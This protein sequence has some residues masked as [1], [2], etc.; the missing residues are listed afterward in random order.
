MTPQDITLIA[1]TAWRENR[2]GGQP[3]MQSVVN[4]IVNRATKSGDLPFAV[5]TRHA[6]FSSI[7]MPGPESYLWPIQTN[8]ADWQAWTIALSL[9]QE[10]ADGTLPDITGGATSYYAASMTTPPSW[11]A[12]MTPTVTIEGQ[13]FFK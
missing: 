1:L 11:A 8:Q 2:G 7:S 12:Q 5:C 4:V 6:Q 9:A 13:L 3:G 10:A